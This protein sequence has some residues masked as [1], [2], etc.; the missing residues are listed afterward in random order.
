MPPAI[1]VL[2]NGDQ[3]LNYQNIL[4]VCVALVRSHCFGNQ[5]FGNQGDYLK[6]SLKRC[7]GC[8]CRSDV[9]REIGVKKTKQRICSLETAQLERIF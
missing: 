8:S 2:K 5:D 1:W 6:K 9:E 7:F 4:A 3:I